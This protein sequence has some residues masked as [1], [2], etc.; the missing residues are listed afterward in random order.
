MANGLFQ[1]RRTA[2]FALV[3]RRCRDCTCAA[4]PYDPD[5][6]AKSRQTLVMPTLRITS[7]SIWAVSGGVLVLSAL[8]ASS[9]PAAAQ[10]AA[11]CPD[12]VIGNVVIENRSVFD[13]SNPERPRR[14][15]WAYS[16]A[17]SL[18]IR[19]NAQVIEREILFETGDCYD[20]EVMRDSE[21]LLR[22]FDFIASANIYGIRSA[23]GTVDVVVDTQDEWS[24]LVKPS[25][26]TRAGVQF[27]GLEIEESNVL[28][29]GQSAAVFYDREREERIYGASYINPQLFR[30][31][32]NLGLQ[33]AKTEV[34]QSYYQALTYPFVGEE[35]RIA[36]RQTVGRDDRY[37]E[38]LMPETG[39]DLAGILVPV[40]REHFE[41]GVAARWGAARFRHTIVGLA[42]AGERIDYPAP[43]TLNDPE[44]GRLPRATASE[45]E[46]SWLPV[47]SVRMMLL[48]GQRNVW[49]V[50]RRAIDTVN[51]IEDVQLGV[52]AEGSIGPSLPVMSEE[53]DLSTGLGLY[54]AGEVGSGQLIG[55]QFEVEARRSYESL[56]GLPEWH[57]VLAQ[58]DLW[59]YIRSRPDSRHTIVASLSGVGGWH[60]R[61][62]F[63][64]TLGG[65]S[66]LR[67]YPNHVDPGGRRIVA[68]LEHRLFLGWPLPELGDLGTVIFADVGKIWPGNVAFGTE[69][70]IRGSFGVGLRAAF[71][72]GS[73][74]TFRIDIGYPV[75]RHTGFGNLALSVG[76]GQSVGRRVQHRDPQLVRSARYGLSTSDFVDPATRPE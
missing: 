51:G 76:V 32:W 39:D 50:R 27:Q 46:S 67:G 41:I 53:Y 65:D 74:Q 52:E 63:Q 55:G 69:S 34:G 5:D 30:S 23:D 1:W 72:P 60:G 40:S 20:V 75:E 4:R 14:F 21:R 7:R 38:I 28:G 64:L 31:R 6:P 48:A 57:D 62:P 12:G 33:V 66:G 18:H 11:A 22:A 44:G 17:N 3:V 56:E 24:T 45:L 59:A 42:L 54:A 61:V 29:S 2:T 49:F 43:P 10:L 19:T 35:G 16:F 58:L 68:S 73:R 8:H 71:P 47:S 25:V 13:L 9:A 15:R 70:P 26:E 36:Y 37:F